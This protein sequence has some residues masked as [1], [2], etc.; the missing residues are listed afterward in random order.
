MSLPPPDPAFILRSG[1]APITC[2]TIYQNETEYILSGSEKGELTIWDMKTKRKTSTHKIHNGKGILSVICLMHGGFATQGRDGV[3]SFWDDNFKLI[4]SLVTEFIGFC[5]LIDIKITDRQVLIIPFDEKSLIKIIDPQ[6]KSELFTLKP[7]KKYGMC[8]SMVAFSKMDYPQVLVGYED[9]G[10][11]LWDRDTED[12]HH[13]LFTEPVMCIGYS[14]ELS[15]GVS[16]SAENNLIL[17]S[18]QEKKLNVLKNIEATGSGF[19]CIKFRNDSRIFVTGGWDG[20]GRVYGAKSGKQLAVLSYHTE[21][22]QSVSISQSNLIYL[23][24]KDGNIS[25]WNVYA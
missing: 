6:D 23:G 14:A 4:G 21:S 2:L 18:L 16:G 1:Q 22:I 17:W 8:M 25:I 20:Q 24:S 9:G 10:I 7:G 19:N 15:R 3:V 11:S 13:S 5:P 12:F